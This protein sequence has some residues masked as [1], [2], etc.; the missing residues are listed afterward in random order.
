L[1][2]RRALLGNRGLIVDSGSPLANRAPHSPIGK[3]LGIGV[4]ETLCVVD[5][6]KYI[7]NLTYFTSLNITLKCCIV[8]TKTIDS[9]YILNLTYFT[10]LNITL[11]CRIIYTKTIDSKYI[12]NLIYFTSLNITLKCC[13][14]Y[15]KTIYSKYILNLIYLTS[16]NITLKCRIIMPHY[17]C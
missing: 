10:S 5:H 4:I 9:K 14:V 1:A 8:Y 17:I 15:I 16:L 12:L 6:S 3:Y 2:N 13:I 7:L 11:K